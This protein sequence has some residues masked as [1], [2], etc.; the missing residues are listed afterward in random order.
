M[1]GTPAMGRTILYVSPVGSLGGGEQ[2]LRAVARGAREVGYRTHFLCMRPGELVDCLKADGFPVTV[3]R[4]HRYRQFGTV[5]EGCRLVAATAAELR[6]DLIHVNHAG[7]IYCR[8]AACPVITHFHDYP[9]RLDVLDAIHRLWKP[10]NVIFTSDYVRRG[11]PHLT[12]SR[13]A[14]I[15]PVVPDFSAGEKDREA[16]SGPARHGP[17]PGPYFLTVARLQPHKGLMD[18]LTAIARLRDRVGGFRFVLV[19]AAADEEQRRFQRELERFVEEHNLQGLVRFAGFASDADLQQLYHG[20]YALVHPARTEG[21]GLVLLEAMRRSIPVI[22]A[23]AAGPRMILEHEVSGLLFPAGDVGALSDGIA[24]LIGESGLRDRLATGGRERA[25]IFSP[26]AMISQTLTFYRETLDSSPRHHPARPMNRRSGATRPSRFLIVMPSAR[27]IGGAEEILTQFVRYAPRHGLEVAVVFLERGPL[28]AAIRALQVPVFVLEAGRLR[29]PVRGWRTVTRLA[30]LIGSLQPEVVLSWMTKGQIYAGIAA[31]QAG[32]A[33][34]CFQRGL[35]ASDVVDRLSR[36]AP[37]DGFLTC[38]QYVA[39]LQEKHTTLPVRA[40]CSAVDL[41]RFD[42]ASRVPPAAMRTRLGLPANGPIVMIVG[43]LQRWKGIHIFVE[44]IELLRQNYP[45][46]AG[47]IVGGQY[48]LEPLYLEFLQNCIEKSGLQ[49]VVQMAGAQTNVPEW[50]QAADVFVHASDREPFGIA[51]LEAMSLGKPVVA[52]RPG[53]PEEIIT[54]GENGLLVSHGDATALAHAI[55]R[56]LGDPALA[57]RCGTAAAVRARNFDGA[58]YPRR[59]QS[60]L[61]DLLDQRAVK[62]YEKTGLAGSTKPA[63]TR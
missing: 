3:F 20:A 1:S 24:R 59:V 31:R 58:E 55:S 2:V 42:A 32:V 45:E 60:A 47:V 23:D 5:G 7:W 30:Q 15:L 44:A 54:D 25:T 36:R 37:C 11:Y 16:G 38:S 21:F 19:G 4:H 43:R 29:Q 53:G 49:S 34:Y 28:A 40:V 27:M 22:A 10:E 39:T 9:Y 46:I 13:Q 51:I 17:E 41:S 62:A 12:E 57:K 8:H 18:L 52:T 48:H 6:A 35:P 33:T 26:D 56:F 63:R 50:V 14:T 61:R